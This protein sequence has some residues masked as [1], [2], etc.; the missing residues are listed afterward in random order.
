M[1]IRLDKIRIKSYKKYYKEYNS[2]L[3]IWNKD[4][5]ISVFYF[6]KKYRF[7]LLSLMI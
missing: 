2:Q 5:E 3:K 7:M 6:T 4:L 1:V